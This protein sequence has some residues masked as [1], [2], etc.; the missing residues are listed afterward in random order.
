[1]HDRI[2]ALQ[3]IKDALKRIGYSEESLVN[4]YNVTTTGNNVLKLDLVAFS[5]CN[6]HDTT[7]SCISVQW[8]E[9]RKEK[10]NV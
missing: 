2:T 1:M 4:N 5:D 7:T 8:C 9:S 6:I 10:E 3:H